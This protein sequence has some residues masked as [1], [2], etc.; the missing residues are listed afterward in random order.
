[1]LLG[2]VLELRARSQTNAAI[3]L[4]LGLAP[5]TARIV[6]DDGPAGRMP[7]RPI[8]DRPL[9]VVRPACGFDEHAPDQDT[10]SV[11]ANCRRIPTIE[12]LVPFETTILSRR[13]Y[14]PVAAEPTCQVEFD[15]G[16]G[17]RVDVT[18]PA[19]IP[20]DGGAGSASRTQSQ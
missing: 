1:M 10:F 17:G 3:K 16:D 12:F 14:R 6:R 7:G 2:Q 15:L 13:Q 8:M 20:E 4:L 9:R 19:A 11:L 18:E 5:K